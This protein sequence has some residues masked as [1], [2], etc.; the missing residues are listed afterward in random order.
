[1]L[2]IDN[3]YKFFI[4]RLLRTSLSFK[5]FVRDILINGVP[6]C[7]PL[8][9]FALLK[10]RRTALCRAHPDDTSSCISTEIHAHTYTHLPTHVTASTQDVGTH[11]IFTYA[12]WYIYVGS[13]S[14]WRLA[15][16]PGRSARD[17]VGERRQRTSTTTVNY[18]M[19]GTPFLDVPPR[20]RALMSV[21]RAWAHWTDMEIPSSFVLWQL[22]DTIARCGIVEF[23]RL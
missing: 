6:L 13:S 8:Q 11:G 12:N 1:L 2:L 23:A 10:R 17:D 20:R 19:R 3:V 5:Y 15:V 14:D 21:R 4:Q 22:P 18:V 16:P 7:S 9:L